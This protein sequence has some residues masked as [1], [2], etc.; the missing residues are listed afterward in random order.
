MIDKFQATVLLDDDVRSFRRWA[1]LI[2]NEPGFMMEFLPGAENCG[3]DILSR[4]HDVRTVEDNVIGWQE[5]ESEFE[6]DEPVCFQ[7]SKSEGKFLG[8]R[9]T[10][11]GASLPKRM[12]RG[13]AGYDLFSSEDVIISHGGR[14]LVG[15]GI[16][17][18]MPEGVYGRI[19]PR[20]GL[21]VRNGINVGAGVIDPDYTGEIKV[22][23]FNHSDVD[24]EVK[25]GDRVGQL[26]LERN[27]VPQIREF[28]E[29]SESDRGTEGFGSTGVS[30]VMLDAEMEK[31]V[32]DEHLKAHWGAWK[33]YQALRR[34][35][36]KVKMKTVKKIVGMCEICA[37]FR[38]E[39]PRSAWHPLLY[40]EVPGEVVYADVIGPLMPGRGGVKYIHCIVDSAS[41]L[42]SVTKM[43]NTSSARILK[44]LDDWVQ[45]R[46]PIKTLVTDNAA[47]YSSEDMAEWCEQKN[48]THRFIAPYR[49][50][51]M[52]LVERFNR[53]LEDRLR[54][55]ML[56]YGGSWADHLQAAGRS[57]NEAVHSI[58]G[59]APL[60]LW[61]GTAEML[62][63]AMKRTD[64]ERQ[65]RNKKKK[66]FPVNFCV[67]QMVL[68]REYDP[69]KQGKF[70]PLW[71][72]PYRLTERLS[73]TMWKAKKIGKLH[74]WGRRPVGVFH[75][76]QL[77]LF[78]L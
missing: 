35:G 67:G 26:I 10:T 72:G 4:P 58:T 24:F 42:S 30:N 51:S 64:E 45:Q 3:A 14:S 63:L 9:R 27:M 33:T 19:A 44:I 65:R 38:G 6:E 34:Q 15:T 46:G 57:I 17:I 11:Y 37:K 31:A 1:W 20:S 61:S 36:L 55:M 60:E 73:D 56:T 21:A 77:Q 41:R 78:E 25:K 5:V 62:K 48:I 18:C 40:S 66:I 13:A 69:S 54:K 59:Y 71:K 8:V 76:D 47:Y 28:W 32:W 74:R 70:D 7:V 39:F 23:L 12:T 52:G 43:K 29:K 50:Q 2:A 53:T 68:V 16:A 22:L 75:E 49:H